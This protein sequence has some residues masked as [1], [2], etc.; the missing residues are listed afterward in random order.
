MEFLKLVQVDG[1]LVPCLERERHAGADAGRPAP[2][3]HLELGVEAQA[4]R[5][6]KS[7]RP[8]NAR[9]RTDRLIVKREPNKF[10]N[11]SSATDTCGWMA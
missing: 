9:P 2:G 5:A 7:G 4:F 3:H 10:Q 1:A 8:E 11:I 6:R